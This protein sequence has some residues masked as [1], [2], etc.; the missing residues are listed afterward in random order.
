MH[1][2]LE[3]SLR[4]M[5]RTLELADPSEC[6]I[7]QLTGWLSSLSETVSRVRAAQGLRE[8][9]ADTMKQIDTRGTATERAR[10]HIDVARALGSVNLFDEAYETLEQA[11][12]DSLED[13]K[14]I[15]EGWVAEI[16]IA[17]RQG[18]FVRAASAADR[19]EQ[20]GPIDDVPTLLAIS[21]A[22]ASTGQAEVAL[23][24]IDRVDQ[25]GEPKDAL[26]ATSRRRHRLLIYFNA[27]NFEA[28]AREAKQFAKLARIAGLRY[29]TA[30]ALHNLGD[31]L[32]RMD[33]YAGAYAAFVESLELTRLI[34]HD[35]LSALNQ[36]H[37]HYL[38][39]L[40][41][42]DDADEQLKKLIRY[43]DG[44]GYLWDVLE[45]RLLLAKLSVARETPETARKQ[46]AEVIEMAE[47]HGH[48][49]IAVDARQLLE[50][51][52]SPA[53]EVC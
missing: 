37:I 26:E 35:R 10:A 48:E 12:L 23:K 29:D 25:L 53:P 36:M 11:G 28:A 42:A 46:L 50:E 4:A 39:G 31:A 18:M 7:E 43:A 33:D 40:R 2:Q 51:L 13:Q 38:D 1:G 27:R 52:E 16:Y 41:N 9:V 30:A 22:R 34:E 47:K 17:I 15:R 5:L 14:L 32:T 49:L 19:L 6:S 21:Q 24:L 44:H 45:G 20:L 3:A 8:A